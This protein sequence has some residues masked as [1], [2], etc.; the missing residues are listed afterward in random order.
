M[1]KGGLSGSQSSARSSMRQ[2]HREKRRAI[3]LRKQCLSSMR[4]QHRKERQACLLPKQ[5]LSSMGEQH[6]KGK[7][8]SEN[9]AFPHRV[10]RQH[11]QPDHLPVQTTATRPETSGPRAFIFSVENAVCEDSCPYR[12][13]FSTEKR[14]ILLQSQPARFLSG[15]AAQRGLQECCK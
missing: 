13:A 11:R 2:Q 14:R 7:A 3:W 10:H 15:L 4:Q 5:C 1:R 8:S 6:R 12:L 9:N